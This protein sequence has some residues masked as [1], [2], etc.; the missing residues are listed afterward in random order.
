M[1]VKLAKLTKGMKNFLYRDVLPDYIIFSKKMNY[2]YCTACQREVDIDF[3][4]AKHKE[5]TKCPLCKRKAFYKAEHYIKGAFEDFGCGIIYTKEDDCIVVHHFDVTKIYT[6]LGSVKYYN[7]KE[8]LREYFNASG[9]VKG[10]DRTYAYGWKKL[11]L[12]EYDNMKGLKGQPCYHILFSWKYGNTYKGN[13][14]SVIKGTPWEHSCLDKIYKLPDTNHYW[15]VPRTFL[16]DYL[17]CPLVE[18]LYKIGFTD[19]CQYMMFRGMIPCDHTK[20]SII[21]ILAVNRDNWKAL[22]KNGNP[23]RYELKKR[24]RMSQYNLSESEYDFFEKYFE[25]R[26]AVWSYHFNRVNETTDYDEFKKHYTQSLAK[27]DKYA[28]TQ[29]EFDLHTYE[30]YLRMCDD[31]G[32]NM[33]NTFIIFPKD[34]EKEHQVVVQKWNETKNAREIAK[35]KKRNAEY[36]HLRDT[37]RDLYSFTGDNFQIVVPNGCEDICAE[38]QKLHHCVGTYIDKV[39]KGISVILFVRRISNLTK[40]YY[41]MELRNNEM[42]QCRGFGNKGVTDEVRKFITDF[43]K[44]RNISM[45]YIA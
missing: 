44:Q 23:D 28:Q 5:E 25:D 45:Q 27:L 18:Y 42:I 4:K 31:L 9:W 43:A 24:Q 11:N 10:F 38:G 34:L 33:Y 8:T 30:D 41:T 3:S 14:K 12:R 16:L 22:L 13:L 17:K 40:S 32:Y 2:A 26:H 19:L 35:A 39:C 7:T 6:N 21:D 15:D 20:Q 37:Y 36:V 29:K 1:E